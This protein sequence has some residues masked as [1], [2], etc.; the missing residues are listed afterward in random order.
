MSVQLPIAPSTRGPENFV[1]TQGQTV[2]T[3]AYPIQEAADVT[4]EVSLDG[5][6]TWTAKTLNTDYAIA[7][8]GAGAGFTITLTTGLNA[9]DRLRHYG[10]AAV[11]RL[12]DFSPANTLKKAGLETELD[13]QTIYI[14]ELRRDLANLSQIDAGDASLVYTQEGSGAVAAPLT[15]YIVGKKFR[16]EEFYN[17]GDA[18]FTLAV[19][20]M[21]VAA[22]AAA[23]SRGGVQALI[24]GPYNIAGTV[25]IAAVPGLEIEA[26]YP[27]AG[28]I[29]DGSADILGLNIYGPGALAAAVAI[30]AD[31]ARKQDFIVVADVT[32]FLTATY[33]KFGA[34]AGA[35]DSNFR[36]QLARI[37]DIDQGNAKI[38]VEQPLEF[39]V[40]AA[41]GALAT[42]WSLVEKVRV[43]GG[44]TFSKGTLSSTGVSSG[45]VVDS[46][47][48]PELDFRSQ[49]IN[50]G[51]ASGSSVSNCYG[52]TI[53]WHDRNS[54]TAA[55]S[56]MNLVGLA[57]PAK[58]RAISEKA[59]SFAISITH[60]QG[61]DFSGTRTSDANGRA[62]RLYGACGNTGDDIVSDGALYNGL[63]YSAGSCDNFFTKVKTRNCLDGGIVSSGTRNH[64]NR[65][66]GVET[67]GNT[68]YDLGVG[69]GDE[70]WHIDNV[71][72]SADWTKISLNN[73]ANRATMRWADGTR[74]GTFRPEWPQFGGDISGATS[75]RAAV[76]ACIAALATYAATHDDGRIAQR[77]TWAI[78]YPGL[79]LLPLRGRKY[80]IS[81]DDPAFKW[82]VIGHWPGNGTQ[83]LNVSGP[84]IGTGGALLTASVTKGKRVLP[85]DQTGGVLAVPNWT[86]VTHLEAISESSKDGQDTIEIYRIRSVDIV[87]GVGT[88][89]LE[90][91]LRANL[92]HTKYTNTEATATAWVRPLLPLADGVKL[93]GRQWID[94]WNGVALGTAYP[95]AGVAAW[96]DGVERRTYTGM[97]GGIRLAFLEN[98]EAPQLDM[99]FLSAGGCSVQHC[100]K[101]K[102]GGHIEDSAINGTL[103]NWQFISQTGFKLACYSR[104]NRT[105]WTQ[106]TGHGFSISGQSDCDGFME[107]D[108]SAARGL[109][110]QQRYG[111]R[112]YIRTDGGKET[113]N[114]YDPADDNDETV[115]ANDNGQGGIVTLADTGQTG[116]RLRAQRARNNGLGADAGPASVVTFAGNVGT[117]DGVFLPVENQR[118]GFTNSGGSL[119]SPLAAQTNYYAVNVDG[120]DFEVANTPDGDPLT[121]T[122]GSGTHTVLTG[123]AVAP[124][125]ADVGATMD[126]SNVVELGDVGTCVSA[127]AIIIR[128]PMPTAYDSNNPGQLWLDGSIVVKGSG[129]AGGISYADEDAQD[130]VGL[131]LDD[132]SVGDIDFTYNDAGP[133][134][135]AVVKAAAITFAKMQAV[136]ANKV[137]GSIAGGSP[138]E[139]AFTALMRSIAAETTAA[140]MRALLGALN[141]GGDVM[142]GPLT[143]WG[144]P[145]LPMHAANKQYV[146]NVIQGLDAKDSVK[147]A[148]T[149]DITLSGEQTIDGVLTSTSRVLVKNQSTASQNGIYVSAAGAWSRASDAD[150]W[151][152]HIGAYCFV[153]Q[154]T[155]QGDTGWVC[156][157]DAGG[158]L[159]STAIAFTQFNG[160][161]AS[162]SA[163]T[164]LGLAGT[165]FSL[166]AP[167]TAALGGTGQTSYTVGDVLYASG[168]TAL[169]KL[170][171]VATG[172]ALIS[173]GVGT[174]PAWGKVGLT[175]H[176]SGVLP[177]ANGGT[178]LAKTNYINVSKSGTQSISGTKIKL[179]FDTETA[180]A[181]GVWDNS[182]HWLVPNV[183][184]KCRFTLRYTATAINQAGA[185]W[186][187]VEKNASTVF[188]GPQRNMASTN[189]S[190]YGDLV[191]GEI[192]VNGSTDKL[193]FYLNIAS[194]AGTVGAGTYTQLQ[195]RVLPP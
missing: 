76:Q 15:S 139:I 77:G 51:Q 155:T 72:L 1:A 178:G 49:D 84:G 39:D 8:A 59:A 187:T 18:D 75:I 35:P 145:T 71:D 90:D 87:D 124:G 7:G 82:K 40:I 166:T 74:F 140:G 12:T 173:G 107:S 193:E 144:D 157:V 167:V 103:A 109:Q 95:V 126:D 143:L 14:Q 146:D 101:G 67:N 61:V 183:A 154:G 10:R 131:I 66:D 68:L 99:R 123:E 148:T 20:R 158:T 118:I 114:S 111:N 137:L 117:T 31:A 116:N 169:S 164:G 78:D 26:E 110:G 102:V 44:L 93:L 13:R 38:Y 19:Q 134:I 47:A 30:S 172:N 23:V 37:R 85:V 185:P 108:G 2:F 43:G 105:P 17:Q 153:E 125:N 104:Y 127:G 92:D 151:A 191:T 32:P 29:L 3:G 160:A 170:A 174:A 133:L 88:I 136:A 129:G 5:G 60:C 138:E 171:A 11:K 73:P 42:P 79:T 36:Y 4:V 150:S 6:E 190:D 188:T 121:I 180:D 132:G 50:V 55:N 122:G 176:V 89:T 182:N 168:A 100:Y 46:L 156:T 98:V 106:V 175:T 141:I 163:G 24:R 21:A 97:P 70:D 69:L 83:L 130:A 120:A 184:G 81:P 91:K 25:A 28:F 186:I 147:C 22:R 58:V 41:D 135:S 52:G 63:F 96:S 177:V 189:F 179:T 165:V 162:Y 142:T 113:G 45:L 53:E 115:E 9:G 34:N 149:A 86:G 181:D 128:H 80:E 16:P 161:G 64:R 27:G 192:D 194:A 48:A 62:I 54:G 195:A 152:E 159:G 33:L 56:A 57:G 65:L 112:C 119:P 94:G